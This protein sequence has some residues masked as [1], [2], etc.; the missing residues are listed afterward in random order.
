MFT[1]RHH[2]TLP[3]GVLVL[4]SANTDLGHDLVNNGHANNAPGLANTCSEPILLFSN[5]PQTR[6]HVSDFSHFPRLLQIHCF[7]GVFQVGGHPVQDCGH[8]GSVAKNTTKLAS[9]T[10]KSLARWTDQCHE[11]NVPPRNGLCCRGLH[12]DRNYNHPRRFYIHPHQSPSSF[13]SIPAVKICL[14]PHCIH[15]CTTIDRSQL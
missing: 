5:T 12:R 7:P 6:T 4:G 14:H 8:S 9:H 3:F 13:T 10:Y 11:G 1:A 15:D 2:N